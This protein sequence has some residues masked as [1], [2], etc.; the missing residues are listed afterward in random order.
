VGYLS[1]VVLL[2]CFLLGRYLFRHM[3]KKEPQGV[4]A[5]QE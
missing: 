3:D 5:S 2:G 1:I 4:I